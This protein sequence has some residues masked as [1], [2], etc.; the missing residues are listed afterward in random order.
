[1]AREVME[2]GS[3]SLYDHD[4]LPR[5]DP[6]PPQLPAM[7]RPHYVTV[8]VANKVPTFMDAMGGAFVA[9]LTQEGVARK[10]MLGGSTR[11]GYLQL[12]LPTP[13]LLGSLVLPTPRLL[14]SL[15]HRPL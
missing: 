11:Y 10:G 1:M 4:W 14:G 2:P 7:G 13:R 3:W 9:L 5:V 8:E 6:G 12:L 15:G